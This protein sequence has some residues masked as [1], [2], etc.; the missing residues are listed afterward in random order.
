[1]SGTST[2][3]R[4]S[5]MSA[6]IAKFGPRNIFVREQSLTLLKEPSIRGAMQDITQQVLLDF[7]NPSR[8]RSDFGIPTLPNVQGSSPPE[9]GITE[10]LDGRSVDEFAAMAS[11]QS[12]PPSI[13]S[14]NS[15]FVSNGYAPSACY[16]QR[17]SPD[18]SVSSSSLGLASL[19]TSTSGY[20]L[21]Q[22]SIAT[23][24]SPVRESDAS[25]RSISSNNYRTQSG[26]PHAAVPYP[27]AYGQAFPQ[28]DQVLQQPP[29]RY[30]IFSENQTL[31]NY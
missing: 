10:S 20:H 2:Q 24:G 7:H 13:S 14:P 8:F 19:A 31:W 30:V 28:I 6:A 22:A 29:R 27:S 1:M 23:L 5:R 25:T 3:Q 4:W 18:A 26:H 9:N 12:F 16:S 15:T 17:L 21:G 11:T